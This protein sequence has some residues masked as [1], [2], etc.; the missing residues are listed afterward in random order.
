LNISNDLREIWLFSLDLTNE[1]LESGNHGLNVLHASWEIVLLGTVSLSSFD[2]SLKVLKV[3]KGLDD[4]LGLDVL[5]KGVGVSKNV[6]EV[7]RAGAL[8]VDSGDIAVGFSLFDISH[9]LVDI[10]KDLSKIWLARLDLIDKVGN[11]LGNGL[12]IR[13]AGWEVSNSNGVSAVRSSIGSSSDESAHVSDGLGNVAGLDIM[14]ETLGSTDDGSNV[15]STITI[16]GFLAHLTIGLSF[17]GISHDSLDVLHDGGEV[18]GS[19]GGGLDDI[20]DFEDDV[21]SIRDTGSHVTGF[22]T[23]ELTRELAVMGHG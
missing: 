15:T 17:L 9:E 2:I 21:L 1:I 19:R 13:D 7:G 22:E 6:L 12:N 10:L 8:S 16:V 18:W 5:D 14:D 23:V 4:P 11:D 20:L 3:V